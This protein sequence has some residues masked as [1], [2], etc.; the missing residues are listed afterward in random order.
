MKKWLYDISAD[1]GKTY[2]AQWLTEDE[3]RDEK[4]MYGHIVLKRKHLPVPA[5]WN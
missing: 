1:G 2:T 3:A 4:E 5:Y